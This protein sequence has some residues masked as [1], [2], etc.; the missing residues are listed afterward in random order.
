MAE[1]KITRENF[2][3]EVLK[4][5][6]PV[7]IDFWASWCGPCRMLSPTI[8]GLLFK[9]H[10]ALIFIIS[11]AA[12]ALSTLLIL[13]FVRDISKEPD[14]GG[15]A[16]YQQER[17]AGVF[18]V[19]R[20]NRILLLY[21][22][23]AAVYGAVYSQYSYI[24]PLD[25]GR[26]HGEDGALIFGTISSLNCIVVV[27]FT[28][29]FTKLLR[30]VSEIKKLLA[31]QALVGTGYLLFLLLLGHIPAYYC[32]MLLFTWGEIFATLADGPYLT[33]RIPASHRGR[34]TGVISVVSAVFMGAIEISVGRLYDKAG[35]SAAWI[36]IISLLAVSA[37]LTVILLIL[38]KKVYPK[39][40]ETETPPERSE[41]DD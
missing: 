26:V 21:V 29:L 12:I 40:Y 7:L 28:P 34:V 18:A 8:A 37:L 4:S 27:L 23:I 11:G 6:K 20:E 39:L 16:V 25:M 32:A 36:L 38:D 2:E 33:K 19:L 35:S 9:D 15:E 31:G 1:L 14:D 24:M 17:K 10:L 5:D 13:F 30:R 3:Q 22:V 41:T